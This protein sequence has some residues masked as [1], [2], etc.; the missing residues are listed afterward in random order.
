M[1]SICMLILDSRDLL[2]VFGTVG[3]RQSDF[4]TR[5]PAVQDCGLFPYSGHFFFLSFLTTEAIENRTQAQ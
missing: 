3:L 5:R 4:I 2:G 1:K